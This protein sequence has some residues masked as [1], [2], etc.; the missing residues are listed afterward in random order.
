MEE[1]EK[2]ITKIETQKNNKNR[3]NVYINN[4]FGFSCDTELIYIYNF[5]KGKKLEADYIK[6]IIDED[7]FV[8]CKNSALRTIERSY[9][10]EYQITQKLIQKGF[11]DNA[12]N[13]V[14]DFLKKYKFIDDKRF[15]K[16]YIMEKIKS[17]GK[18]KIKCE[19]L[20]KGIDKSIVDS[21]LKNIDGS[22]EIKYA[23]KL[24]IKKYNILKKTEI[25]YKKVYKKLGNYLITRGYN[26]DILKDVLNQVIDKNDCDKQVIKNRE[27]QDTNN[28]DIDE[29]KRIAKRRYD[30]ISKSENSA[31]R[32]YRKLGN[33]LVRR[34]YSYENIRK[35]LKLLID[36]NEDN[37]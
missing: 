17:Q 26:Q 1:K 33:Y 25:N 8:K 35:V 4:E 9:K 31:V 36:F 2:A 7:N 23:I 11:E 30:I 16:S 29:L 19:L 13:R 15:I 37:V 27:E 3:V 24:A 10:T 20:K 18:N 28:N 5:I 22:T 32:I 6:K 34:G 14:I 12:I 21:E